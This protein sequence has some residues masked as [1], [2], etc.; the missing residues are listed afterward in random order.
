LTIRTALAA[1]T[2]FALLPLAAAPADSAER[3]TYK[4]A[5]EPICKANKEAS[6][7]ILTGV[8]RMVRHDQLSQAAKRFTHAAAAL[9]KAR[10][11]LAGVPQPPEDAAKLGKWL[12]GIKGEV[13]LMKTIAAKFRSGDKSRGSSLVV[14][15]KNNASKTNNLVIVFQFDYCKIDPSAIK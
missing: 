3:A 12:S 9:E 2:L 7:R 14:K 13:S 5:V 4:A 15:L 10:K 8:E 1:L 11:Q 6:Q